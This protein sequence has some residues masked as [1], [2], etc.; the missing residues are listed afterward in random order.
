MT[1]TTLPEATRTGNILERSVCIVLHCGFLGNRRKLR[2]DSVGMEKDGTTL[3]HEKD[4]LGATKRLFSTK[5]LQAP[6]K[7]IA[8]VKDRL[9]A[10]SVDGGTRMFGDGAYLIPLPFVKEARDVISDGQHLLDQ[11]VSSLVDRLP[12]LIEERKQKLGKLFN[13]AEYPTADDVKAAYKIGYT[14]VSFGAPDR[15]ADVDEA[16]AASAQQQW[17]ERLSTA[18]EDVVLGL[19]E[20][21]ASVLREL[22]ERLGVGDDGKPKAIRGTALRDVNEL[23]E[24]LPILNSIGED[25]ELASKLSKV[26]VYLKG[27]DPDVLRKAPA[28]REQL[29]AIA[30]ETAAELDKLVTTGKRAISFGP[31][32]ASA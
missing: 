18:Y 10:M 1:P 16:L 5:D 15:L 7:A 14:F 31:L 27:L 3:T 4:E 19:R 6:S 30:T 2:L 25:D 29:Q 8:S 32:A 11:S 20:S 21:A 17:N 23:L 13:S 9:R 28:V 24:R 12:A 22:A 26:G